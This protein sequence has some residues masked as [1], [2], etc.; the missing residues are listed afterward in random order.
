MYAL[1]QHPKYGTV[2]VIARIHRFGN[3]AV[4]MGVALLT[5]IL[6]STISE[7]LFSVIEILNL[8]GLEVSLSK[9]ETFQPLDIGMAS[10]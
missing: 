5:I 7:Y 4:K 3:Q 2:S 1:N 10:L 9:E 8:T 6:S